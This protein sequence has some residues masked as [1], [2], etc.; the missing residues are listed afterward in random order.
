MN[1]FGIGG[2]AVQV[3]GWCLVHFLWQATLVGVAYGV[4]RWLLPRGNPRYLA[5]MLALVALAV[6]PAWTVWH[7]LRGLLQTADLGT[8]LVSAT[9]GSGAA[10]VVPVRSG[11]DAALS[12]ALPW[13]VLAW[14]CGVAFLGLRVIRQWRGLQSIV[15]AAETLPVWQARAVLLGRQLGLRHAV[16]VLASVRIATPTLVGWVRPA[17]VMPLAMLARMPAEQVDLILAHELA[18]LR[19]LDH[20]ANLFQVWLEV[21]FFYHPVVHWISRD[22]RNERELCCDALALRVTGGRRRDFV[23]ALAELEEYRVDH[24]GLALAASGGV[25]VERAWFAAGM[26]PQRPRTRGHG[27]AVALIG[28]GVLAVLGT[29]WWR[30]VAQQSADS[31]AVVP[32]SVPTPALTLALPALASVALPPLA[33]PPV[34]SEAVVA[35]PRTSPQV[36]PAPIKLTVANLSLPGVAIQPV[37]VAT[38]S[39]PTSLVAVATAATPS[40]PRVLRVVAPTYPQSAFENGIRGTVSVAFT[41]DATGRPRDVTVLAAAPQ[42]VFDAAALAALR[43]W[44]FQSPSTPGQRYRQVFS[45]TPSGTRGANAVAARAGCFRVTGTHICRKIDASDLGVQTLHRLTE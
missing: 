17:V 33:L 26:A 3:V 6:F 2:V 4:A 14:G 31:G 19:R 42:G 16:R 15:R 39:A 36:A 38:V 5:A 1:A 9:A 41:V 40:L 18:H 11:W 27:A 28:L 20:F 35:L 30:N 10:A 45:F 44:R 43:Q 8:M 34:R 23:E 32:I 29:T 37:P 13:L 12:I 21:L 7:E 22:A 25:L 24:A